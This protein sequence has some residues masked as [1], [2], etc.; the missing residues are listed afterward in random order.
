MTLALVGAMLGWTLIGGGHNDI[1]WIGVARVLLGMPISGL[2]GGL[3]G[4]FVY[5]GGPRRRVFER[6]A[7]H[8]RIRL[9]L[10]R[11]NHGRLASRWARRARRPQ[12]PSDPSPLATARLSQRRRHS[13]HRR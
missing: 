2:G 4:R 12:G 3:L 10:R 5:G 1:H 13:G 11:C 7:Y 6:H 9:L 8:W